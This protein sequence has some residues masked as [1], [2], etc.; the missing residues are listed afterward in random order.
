MMIVKLILMLTSFLGQDEDR[1][2][3]G[4]GGR[5]CPS[6][7]IQQVKQTDIKKNRSY[8][9]SVIFRQHSNQ[10]FSDSKKSVTVQVGEKVKV[11]GQSKKKGTPSANLDLPRYTA[12]NVRAGLVKVN[13]ED[14][15]VDAETLDLLLSGHS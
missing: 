1:A 5:K 7:N 11:P 13:T 12:S 14:T 8:D 3:E 6:G 10:E 15:E 9:V 2:G 4:V